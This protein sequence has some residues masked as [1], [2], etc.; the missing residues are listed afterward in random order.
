[1]AIGELAD[2]LDIYLDRVKTKY[3]GLSATDRA[4]S[5]SQE[6]LAVVVE[7]K[8]AESFMDLCRRENIEVTH[9]ADVTD[10]GRMRM[11]LGGE[12]IADLSRE[13]IDSAG[14]RHYA[15][16][17]M[18]APG[19]RP[20]GLLTPEYEEKSLKDKLIHI[21]SDNNVTSQ[22]GLI[23]MFDSSIGAST[24]L[25]PF[26][27][28]TQRTETQVSVQEFPTGNRRSNTASMMAFGFNPYLTGWSQYHGA[29]YAVVEAVAKAVAEAA[30][31]S[32]V[33]R[34]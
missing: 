31:K 7:A 10:S 30:R 28:K 33:A 9:V 29:A 20:L 17:R 14:A 32:G 24:V 22:K 6:R 19:P 12:V 5:E 18:A 16:A 2:G 13:F 8:D 1:M 25:M 23:E 34:I 21:L 26:G 15:S 3:S 4:I 27:G 11:M